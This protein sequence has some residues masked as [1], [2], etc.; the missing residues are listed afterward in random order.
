MFTVKIL[1]PAKQLSADNANFSI[2]I[3]V[4]DSLLSTDSG[5]ALNRDPAGVRVSMS[6]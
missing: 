6:R 1:R 5:F 2:L 4:L 3:L